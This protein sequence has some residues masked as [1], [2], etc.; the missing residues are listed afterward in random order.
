MNGSERKNILLA[1]TGLSPQTLTETVYALAV[2]RKPGW[3]PHEIHLVTTADGA[4]RARLALLWD[5]PAWFHRLCRDYGLPDIAF[6]ED[7]V[8]V[9]PD[10]GGN[11]LPDIRTPADNECVADFICDM[12]RQFTVSTKTELHVSIAGGRKTMGYYL[13]YALSLFGR[14]WDR[15]SHVLVSEPYESTWDFFYP[16]PYSRVIQT[17]NGDLADTRNAR[18]MLA[19]IPFVSL[20][21]GLDPALIEGRSRFSEVVSAV[22]ASLGPPRLELDLPGQCIRAGGRE[23]HLPPAQ[24]A[25]LSVFARRAL[26]GRPPLSS[27]PKGVPDE[28]WA[29]RFLKEYR[30]IRSGEMDACERTCRALKKGMDGDYF[31][32]TKAALHRSLR[33]CLGAAASPYLIDDGG[34]RP[35]RY[36]LRLPPEAIQYCNTPEDRHRP[37]K[38]P[39]C[40]GRD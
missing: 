20:R 39:V 11:P 5:E 24:L 40:P 36:G 12:V 22:R 10:A 2:E 33:Q 26:E 1:V 21:H 25:L 34:V 29:D 35:G 31:S 17:R 9:I 7:H 16:T 32:S 4:E 37:G 19:E 30:L 28:R 3:V 13:G 15:L 38:W 14:P 23:C 18:V 8:H 27:P 6:D